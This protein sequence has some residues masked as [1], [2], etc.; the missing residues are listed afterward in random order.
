[1][2]VERRSQMMSG[3]KRRNAAER[4]VVLGDF[5]VGKLLELFFFSTMQLVLV[6]EPDLLIIDILRDYH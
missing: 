4:K 6:A 3:L 1:M 2:S 5:A